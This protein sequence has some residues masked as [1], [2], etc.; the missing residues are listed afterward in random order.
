MIKVATW[1]PVTAVI[2]IPGRKDLVT[3][4]TWGTAVK[5]AKANGCNGIKDLIDRWFIK[6]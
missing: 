6:F 1:Y 5:I 2:E 3:A 4:I